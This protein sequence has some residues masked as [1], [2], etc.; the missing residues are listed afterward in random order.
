[1]SSQPGESPTY[2]PSCQAPPV[3]FGLFENDNPKP[4]E[5]AMSSSQ[6]RRQFRSL[7]ALCAACRAR[8]A[9]FQYRGEV[10]ADRHHTLCFECYRAELNRARARRLAERQ[11]GRLR[12]LVHDVDAQG[13]SASR[14]A[15]R[16]RM[17]DHLR[18]QADLTLPRASA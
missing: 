11:T 10:R 15:H 18:R 1:M 9:R 14:A 5:V 6:R 13:L 7:R 8:K 16:E 3:R 4:E 17:L 12:P 2:D